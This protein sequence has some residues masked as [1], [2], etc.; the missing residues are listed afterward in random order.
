MTK[1]TLLTIAGVCLAVA[2]LILLSFGQSS[3]PNKSGGVVNGTA[4]PT[5]LVRHDWRSLKRKRECHHFNWRTDPRPV[6]SS[7]QP[8][9][10]RR[11]QWHDNAFG[12]SDTWNTE[13]WQRERADKLCGSPNNL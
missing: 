7:W 1:R 3:N 2:A 11:N 10:K 4:R 12:N 5:C 13:S 8:D 9:P 6:R